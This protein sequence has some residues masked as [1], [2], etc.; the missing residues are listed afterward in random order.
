MSEQLANERS[1]YVGNAVSSV[2]Y[3]MNVMLYLQTYHRLSVRTRKTHPKTFYHIYGALLLLFLTLVVATDQLAGQLAWIENRDYP[4][5][6]QGYLKAH[7]TAWYNTLGTV[8]VI[9][10]DAMSNALMLY[11]CYLIW[12][13]SI[14]A[15]L[16]LLVLYF[17][18]VAMSIMMM[19]EGA[20]PGSNIF[21]GLAVQYGIIWIALTVVF[22]I[23]ITV[24]ISF[25]L[26]R[27]YRRLKHVLPTETLKPYTS[28]VAIIVESFL[29]FTIVNIAYMVTL[30]KSSPAEVAIAAVWPNFC[31]LAPQLI[32]FRVASGVAWSKDT[33]H[34]TFTTVSPEL[35]DQSS[36]DYRV[37]VEIT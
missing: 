16:A 6:V 19:L 13:D 8:A 30:I 26:I 4:G 37:S 29:P 32:I 33:T 14:S 2:I 9:S 31:V 3:G 5:G 1:L 12:N 18:A 27:V 28:T 21:K 15:V 34:V 22:N 7:A 20:L 24:M 23:F 11:R 36:I 17:A 35:S 10:L 25:R